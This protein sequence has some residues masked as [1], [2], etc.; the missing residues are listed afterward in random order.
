MLIAIRGRRLYKAH[1]YWPV[2]LDLRRWW[3]AF[4]D[5]YERPLSWRLERF[6]QVDMGDDLRVFDALARQ[7]RNDRLVY[8]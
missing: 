8:L 6:L 1:D 7:C 2:V 4:L 3:T 5:S